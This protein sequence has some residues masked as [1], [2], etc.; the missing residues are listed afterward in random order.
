MF[1]CYTLF[2]FGHSMRQHIRLE[3]PLLFPSTSI[4]SKSPHACQAGAR[5]CFHKS[6]TEYLKTKRGGEEGNF[7]KDKI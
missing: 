4:L 3:G 6:V 2:A 1:S 5:A 7:V